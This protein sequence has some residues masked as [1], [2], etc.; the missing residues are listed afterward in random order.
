[1]STL[2]FFL[3]YL[4]TPVPV[5]HYEG[6]WISRET[7]GTMLTTAVRGVSGGVS[8]VDVKL[9]GSSLLSL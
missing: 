7:A 9:N 4:R 5:I 2:V 1:M 3:G 8:G 6:G